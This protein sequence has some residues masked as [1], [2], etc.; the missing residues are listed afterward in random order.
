MERGNFYLSDTD[1]EHAMADFNK[2]INLDPHCGKAYIGRSRLYQ[3]MKKWQLAF[4][5]LQKAES[6][7]TPGIAIDATFESAFLRKELQQF[8]QALAE[9]DRVLKSGLLSKKRQACAFLQRGEI[10]K[11]TSKHKE[12]VADFSSAV[13]NDP[14]L[15]QAY[16]LRARSYEALKKFKEA[17]ADYTWIVNSDPDKISGDGSGGFVSSIP[18]S[19]RERANIYQAMGRPDLA[20]KDRAAAL[21]NERQTMDIAPFR[22]P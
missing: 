4:G 14:T 11:R 10:Y 7:A 6:M 15:V 22:L 8:P 5:E 13:K 20:R 21:S 9:Y 17:L 2:A 18:E 16:L 3:F 19:Y 12:A 1:I